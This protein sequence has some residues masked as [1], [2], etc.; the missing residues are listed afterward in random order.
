MNRLVPALVSARTGITGKRSSTCTVG[1]AS[2]EGRAQADPTFQ[3]LADE[4]GVAFLYGADLSVSYDAELTAREDYELYNGVVLARPG[5]AEVDWTAKFRLV[6]FAE[7]GKGG[8][9]LGAMYVNR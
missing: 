9:W 6:P 4:T 8:M 7:A 3:D 5:T 1:T 2:R